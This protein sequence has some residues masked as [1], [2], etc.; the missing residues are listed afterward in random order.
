[1][2]VT[3]R[4]QTLF[5]QP[6]EVRSDGVHLLRPR[7]LR[8]FVADPTFLATVAS[9]SQKPA[10]FIEV[11]LS[12]AHAIVELLLGGAG[13]AVPLRPLTDVEE[14]VMVFVLLEVLRAM[15]P[16][17][18]PR[19]PRFHLEGV[20]RNV[21]QWLL[22]LGNESH[23][24]IISL[25]CTVG[26][27]EG[28][29]RIVLPASLLELPVP[30][31]SGEEAARRRERIA[32]H[33]SRLAW[34]QTWL[35]AEIGRVEIV[36]SDLA[37]LQAGDVVLLDELSVRCDRGEGGTA[38][39]RAGLGRAGCFEADIALD[40]EGYTAT[41]RSFR[42]EPFE[43]AEPQEERMKEPP[44]EG[45]ELLSDIPLQIAVELGRIPLT[46]EQV[47]ALHL[48]QVVELNRGPGEPVELSVNGKL[49]A[50]GELVEV[51]GQLGVRIV[52]IG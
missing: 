2:A 29:T 13:E 19:L 6:T 30:A 5:A 43:R 26:A 15:A 14:G 9:L 16:S 50:R 27:Q 1:V 23:L 51:E 22:K 34:I 33:G 11:E 21:D 49:I 52:S 8:R 4:L 35:W 42:N 17:L 46:A 18:E 45:A 36:A 31:S 32:R 7:E 44:R 24:A 28:F 25:R 48:G 41:L 47:L 38:K 10:G 37:S 20:A 3:S 39:L 12:L 40:G